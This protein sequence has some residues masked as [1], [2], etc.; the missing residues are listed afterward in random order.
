MENLQPVNYYHSISLQLFL[1]PF[2][3]GSLI[4]ITWKLFFLIEIIFKM[5]CWP[6]ATLMSIFLMESAYHNSSCLFI[7]LS[8][9]SEFLLQVLNRRRKCVNDLIQPSCSFGFRYQLD[10]LVS[11]SAAVCFSCTK[12][13]LWSAWGSHV[14]SLLWG[15][16]PMV[17]SLHSL[18]NIHWLF[19]FI[20]T[21]LL[22][23]TPPWP[24]L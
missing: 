12:C 21:S 1:N 17:S 24:L 6:A 14:A 3:Y 4:T 10:S 19:K 22:S 18:T 9:F 8:N 16:M 13:C 23:G 11:P 2:T 15:F 7:S 20:K 5:E